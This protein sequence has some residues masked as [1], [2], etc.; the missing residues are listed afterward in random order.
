MS[1]IKRRKIPFHLHHDV[2]STCPCKYKLRAPF[3]G[4]GEKQLTLV[5]NEEDIYFSKLLQTFF[6]F[7]DV[8][9]LWLHASALSHERAFLNNFHYNSQFHRLVHDP[10]QWQI[11]HSPLAYGGLLTNNHQ[12]TNKWKPNSLHINKPLGFHDWLMDCV[13]PHSSNVACVVYCN[14]PSVFL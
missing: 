4:G 3:C 12:Q 9:G 5:L 11:K 7:V 1:Q 6:V 8:V 14:I 10:P 13:F 2:D